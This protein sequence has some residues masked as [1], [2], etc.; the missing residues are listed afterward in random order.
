MEDPRM[1]IRFGLVLALALGFGGCASGGGGG[2]AAPVARPTASGGQI[3]AQ[4]ERPRQTENT[5]AAQRHLDA[6]DKA[7]DPAEARM[8]Y[9]Q[10]LTSAE[11]AIA[12][13]DR[14]PLGHRQAALANLA[15][16][17]YEAAGKEFD[18]ASELRP[19]YELEDAGIRERAW[20]DLYQRAVPLVNQAAYEEATGLFEDANAI[21]AE[22]PEAMI[23]LGQLYAQLR[24]HDKALENL[25]R[26]VAIINSDKALEMDS[27]TVALWQEQ[28][29]G[30]PILRAQVL[31]DAGRFEEAVAA[32][33][34][35]VEANPD[36]MMAQRNLATILVEMG[37]TDEAFAVYDE[38]V[39]RPDLS[40]GDLY[41]IG[42]GFYQGNDYGR[43]AATF[44]QSAAKNV[45]DRDALEMWARSLQLDSA[46][47]EIPAVTERWIELDPNNQNAYLIE[48]QAVN[49]NGDE[50]R[51]REMIAAIEDLRA[52]V[53]DLQ[54]RRDPDGGARVTGSVV[55]KKLN[56]GD[57]VTLTFTFYSEVGDPVGTVTKSVTVGAE[58]MSEVFSVDFA[59][60]EKVGGY[61]YEL[62]VN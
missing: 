6:G 43:A 61:G 30:I 36:D 56:Q 62:T 7:E 1:K 19:L 46:Y 15:L 48:A 41:T 31:A 12:E 23:T 4:G 24:E 57:Q 25:D 29:E 16:E 20:I 8:H 54:I 55:N 35:I 13:D 3:L 21:Y 58:G 2:A 11:A 37:N 18:R 52:G 40:P 9:E 27:A 10:A 26:A 59:S 5:R 49:V 42:V 17:N 38:L 47:T 60:T 45:K 50:D 22:R 34:A 53:S 33:R 51:A 32:F 14:N 44:A 28:A 39:K